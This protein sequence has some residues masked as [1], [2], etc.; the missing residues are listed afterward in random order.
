MEAVIEA[1]A[2]TLNIPDTVG[3]SVPH[4]F[5]ELIQTLRRR[6]R[7]IDGVTIS[8]HC[9]DDLGLSVANSL[10]AIGAGARQVECTVTASVSAPA[11]RHWK[12]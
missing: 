11:T 9:H 10:A 7:G 2:S 6:V 8:V 12:S 1:G 5:A 4:E 3:F